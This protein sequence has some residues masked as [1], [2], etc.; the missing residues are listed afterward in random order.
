M[1]DAQYNIYLDGR[2]AKSITLEPNMM[3]TH[4]I[5]PL[6]DAVQMKIEIEKTTNIGKAQYGIVNIMVS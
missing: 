3:P 1:N 6:N 5:V 4:Y 2:L